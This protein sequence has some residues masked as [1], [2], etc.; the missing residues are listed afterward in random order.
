MS[1]ERKLVK[2]QDYLAAMVYCIK[3]T[4]RGFD[5][6]IINQGQDCRQTYM[7]LLISLTEKW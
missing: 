7:K 4:D 1:L 6:G 2:I 3:I 5:A